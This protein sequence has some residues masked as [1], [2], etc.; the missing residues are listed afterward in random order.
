MA[1]KVEEWTREIPNYVEKYSHNMIARK[2]LPVRKVGADVAVDVVTTYESTGTG[3]VIAAMGTVPSGSRTAAS[4]D[5]HSIVQIL[6]GF[7]VHEKELKLDS[8][9]KSRNL[10]MCIRNLHKKEDELA[11][12]GDT[13]TNISG[14]TD[15]PA[16]AN[17]ITTAQNNG[18]WDG[19]EAN[20][21]YQD[22]L[23]GIG[24]LDSDFDVAGIL[25][26]PV[27]A[28]KLR[29]MSSERQQYWTEIVDLF[30]GAKKFD[31]FVFKSNRVTA[32]NVYLF[33]KDPMAAELVV[34]ENTT[35]AAIPQQPG[36]NYPIEVYEWCTVE[37]HNTDCFVKIA[38]G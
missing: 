27:D 5:K 21:I 19:S 14:I 28:L 25:C 9:I 6:D 11:I 18:A 24:L 30:M 31:D 32:G 16:T 35:V 3:A 7:N 33:V 10:D 17:T 34:A 22:V 29:G 15:A 13:N 12:N 26:N 2:V 8:K 20:D 1:K 38:T 37:I 4:V 36:R 23:T